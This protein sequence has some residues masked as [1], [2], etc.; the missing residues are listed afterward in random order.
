MVLGMPI[1]GQVQTIDLRN[2]IYTPQPLGTIPQ[3]I[4]QLF[5]QQKF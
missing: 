5:L 4:L 3:A 2:C 1:G